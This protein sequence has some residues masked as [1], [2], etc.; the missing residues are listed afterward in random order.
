MSDLADQVKRLTEWCERMDKRLSSLE[1]SIRVLGRSQSS[2][3]E[4]ST[5]RLCQCASCRRKRQ[6]NEKRRLRILR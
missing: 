1:S 2:D 5:H 3:D 4:A 6:A